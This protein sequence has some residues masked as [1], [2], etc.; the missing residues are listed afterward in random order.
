[1]QKPVYVWDGSGW[2]LDTLITYYALFEV[3]AQL[4][5]TADPADAGVQQMAAAYVSWD[6]NNALIAQYL[7]SAGEV[8]AALEAGYAWL[9]DGNR[10]ADD[11]AVREAEVQAAINN[12]G[13]RRF[14]AERAAQV[15]AIRVTRE[16]D[17][18]EFDGDEQSQSR[19]GR[20]VTL[21]NAQMLEGMLQ[22]LESAEADGGI[23]A[24]ELA[25]ALAQAM[26]DGAGMTLNP[27]KTADNGVDELNYEDAR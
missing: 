13:W 4:N 10:P 7:V 23:T 25:G 3:T 6:P 19:M 5:R 27:W 9:L 11:P 16:R 8:K 1:M 2:V 24:A 12:W 26:I 22:V 18:I 20:I 14:K 17:G 15:N 21:G